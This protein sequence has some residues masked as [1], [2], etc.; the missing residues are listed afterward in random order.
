M[1]R[2]IEEKK[3]ELYDLLSFWNGT[4]LLPSTYQNT[5]LLRFLSVRV[6]P[7]PQD[8]EWYSTMSNII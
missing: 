3:E 5:Q 8:P 4:S 7:R 1:L 2:E 6:K